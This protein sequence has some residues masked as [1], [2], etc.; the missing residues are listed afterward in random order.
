MGSRERE[1]GGEQRER[2]R[3][4]GGWGGTIPVWLGFVIPWQ[5]DQ[6]AESTLGRLYSRISGFV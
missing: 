6:P 3:R 2:G 1:G 4:G 5:G